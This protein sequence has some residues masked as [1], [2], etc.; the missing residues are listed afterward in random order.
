MTGDNG[1]N[2]E[3]NT[4]AGDGGPSNEANPPA[5]VL[6]LGECVKKIDAGEHQAD[7]EYSVAACVAT[8]DRERENTE[9]EVAKRQAW[10]ELECALGTADLE[11]AAAEKARALAEAEARKEFTEAEQLREAKTSA[12]A[13]KEER[14]TAHGKAETAEKAAKK[15]LD[16]AEKKLETQEA[17]FAKAQEVINNARSKAKQAKKDWDAKDRDLK[18]EEKALEKAKKALEDATA[19]A[20][21]VEGLENDVVKTTARETALRNAKADFELSKAKVKAAEVAARAA[22]FE[23]IKT[24]EI[25]AR[26]RAGSS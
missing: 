22:Y 12:D 3:G 1:D 9:D 17:A 8:A 23:N 4:V 16:D 26:A 11:L 13:S 19:A 25:N 24:I 7:G 20:E 15:A 21:A 18:V 14:L 5:P 2:A 6:D 10:R